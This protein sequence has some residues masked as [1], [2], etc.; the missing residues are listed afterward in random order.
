[1]KNCYDGDHVIGKRVSEFG[2][3]RIRC[4]KCNAVPEYEE[5][6]LSEATSELEREIYKPEIY[7]ELK[8]D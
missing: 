7:K 1:M 8:N 5:V 3:P 6:E 4:V 2:R